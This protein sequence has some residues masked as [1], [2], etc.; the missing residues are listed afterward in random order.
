[1]T[2][3]RL[4]TQLTVAGV[5]VS[6]VLVADSSGLLGERAAIALD[7]AAQLAGGLFA[8]VCCGLGARR[9]GGVRRNWRRLMAIGM[10]GWSIGQLVWSYYQV[11][12][13]TPL[14]SP[15]WADVGYLTMPV[16]ALAAL[17][18][19]AANGIA[20]QRRQLPA[21]GSGVRSRVVLVLDGLVI[22]GSM[23][24]FTWATALGTVVHAGAPTDLAF[25]VA[26]AY[27]ITDLMLVVIVLLLLA[28]RPVQV[29]MRTE[30]ILLGLGLVGLSSSDSIFAY[31]I[32]SGAEE[33]PPIANAGFIAGPVL[34]GLAALHTGPP[35]ADGGAVRGAVAAWFHLLMP[36]LCML[37]SSVL[38]LTQGLSGR[39]PGN[40]ALFRPRLAAA[41]EQ[42]RR[43]GRPLALLFVDLDDF[44]MV[45]DSLGHAAGDRVL[46]AVAHRLRSCVRIHDTVARLGGDE[47]GVLLEGDIDHPDRVGQRILAAMRQP[48]D[49][50][51]RGVTIGA[52]LGAAVPNV[53]DPGLSA[54]AL[55]RRADAAM[56][57]GKRRGKGL[58]VL[59]GPENVDGYDNPD[60]PTLLAAALAGAPNRTGL[61]V[62]YQP[63]VRMADGGLVAVEAL[64][65]W[66]HPQIGRVPP[67]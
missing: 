66:T 49:V 44:K 36:Y 58:L 8:S 56:Y 19:I 24:V 63:I 45:N 20:A 9:T 65:R 35:R 52:S 1:M 23:L 59:Y 43:D 31:L 17:L 14:P 40:R 30:L 10:L 64:A 38:L 47:F 6:A 57:A 48:F 55:L 37:L 2:G 28:T 13:R 22:V 61:D 46:Q 62:A 42:H 27:P 67:T 34:V 29:W 18:A 54:D 25:A 16:F 41:V 11:F 51:G 33:M 4:R 53:D 60:L 3:P 50:D 7:D 26:I 15:S 12:K 39:P 5:A 21:A 32:A